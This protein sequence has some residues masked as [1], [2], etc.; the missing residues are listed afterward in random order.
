MC[1]FVDM[2]KE[3]FFKLTNDET[4]LLSQEEFLKHLIKF[5]EERYIWY[6]NQLGEVFK[7]KSSFP[8]GDET[9]EWYKENLREEKN[10]NEIN[11]KHLRL[12]IEHLRQGLNPPYFYK[13]YK[14]E[15][16]IAI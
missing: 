12:E 7:D 16:P 10:S 3:E 1:I 6:K 8:P 9:V 14:R 11:L 4:I 2:T 5:T 13:S 15:Y